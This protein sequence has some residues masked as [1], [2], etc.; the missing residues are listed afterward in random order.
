LPLSLP[1]SSLWPSPI[2]LRNITSLGSSIF[3]KVWKGSLKNELTSKFSWRIRAQVIGPCMLVG[4]SVGAS[5]GVMSLS[6]CHSITKTK[7]GT[8]HW[9]K[10]HFFA[11]TG[12]FRLQRVKIER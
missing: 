5:E 11:S 6:G 4:G 12:L 8:F 9:V 10:L 3:S 7:Q 2:F 1:P